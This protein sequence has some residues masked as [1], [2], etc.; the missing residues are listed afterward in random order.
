MLT[1]VFLIFSFQAVAEVCDDSRRGRCVN[2]AE[3]KI[4]ENLIQDGFAPGSIAF[5]ENVVHC[6][7]SSSEVSN[8]SVKILRVMVGPWLDLVSKVKMIDDS[9]DCEVEFLEITL[10]ED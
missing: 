10:S 9:I 1:I 6:H 4:I 2:V 3:Q 8:V 7:N 5:G